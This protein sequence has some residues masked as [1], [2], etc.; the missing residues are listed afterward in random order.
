MHTT[1]DL[2]AARR[3]LVA[4]LHA[5]EAAQ[6]ALLQRLLRAPSA[7][8]PGDT[9]PAASVLEAFLAAEG[10]PAVTHA[11]RPDLPNLVAA[12][13]GA[14]PAG[15]LVFNGH[16]DVFPPNDERGWSGELRDGALYGR[17]AADMKAGTT[18]STLAFAAL[19][20]FR[21]V[22]PGRVTLTAV[23]DEQ[24]GGALGT[25]WLFETMG[26]AIRGDVLLN[27]EPSGINNIRFMEKGT[28]RFTVTVRTAGGHGGYPHLSPSAIKIAA[29]IVHALDSLH[30][31]APPLPEAVARAL[32]DPAAIAA[33]DAGLGQGASTWVR[34]MTFNAGVIRGGRK[35]NQLPDLCELEC[36][37]RY[38]WGLTRASVAANVARI[39]SGFPE[40]SWAVHEN[41]SYPPSLAP[42]DDAMVRILAD[43][44]E[45]DLGAPRPVPCSSLGGS[46]SR[47]WRYAGIPA[48]L[49]GP[50]PVSMGRADEHVTVAEFLHI[51][52]AHALAAFD[53]LVARAA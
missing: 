16:I 38:P 14:R 22:L 52:K 12:F 6:V 8:P 36:D 33:H 18:A 30:G 3:T 45:K 23:S 47:Y 53:W 7:N 5:T 32:E 39:L 50:S 51:T 29:A 15:H 19:H 48:Y 49:Y 4:H 24:T 28:L 41:H 1:E 34:Q 37:I 21:D 42:P 46:D 2:T 40:A 27:G 11:A 17:G 25:R 43:V 35:V 10:C 26:D 13:D 44:V 20:R 31:F 9:R